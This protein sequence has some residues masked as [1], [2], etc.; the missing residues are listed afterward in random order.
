[1]SFIHLHVYSAYSLLAS[2]ASVEQLVANA[3]A[4]GYSALALTDMNNMYGAIKFYKE[5]SKRSIK[6][7]LGVTVDVAG[8]DESGKSYPIVLLASNN[9]GF[10]NLIKITSAVQTK[11]PEGIPVKWLRHYAS[12]LFALS[13]GHAGE[14]EHW[15]EQGEDDR[16]KEA[17]LFYEGIFGKGRF[18]ISLHDQ[19]LEGQRDVME[20]LAVLAREAGVKTA[21]ANTVHYLQKEDAFAQECLL[22]I[23]NGTK[24]QD[25][26]REKLG[27]S[28]FYLKTSAEMAELFSDYPDALEN[29]LK[30]ADECNVMIDLGSRHLPSFPVRKGETAEEILDRL[31]R[32]GLTE[33]YGHP[34][35]EHKERLEYELSVIKKMNFSD[36]FLIVWDFMKFA[37]DNGIL[38]GPGRGS[39][40]GSIVAYSLY[41]TDVDPIRHKLLFERFLNPERITMPDIDIDFPD[42]RRD[43]VIDYV[44]GRYGR[45]HVAQI[46]TFGTLAAK[47]AAR[48]VGR[49]FGLNSNEL[50][51]LSRQIPSKP[52]ITLKSAYKES[53]GLRTFVK[54]SETNQKLFETALKI[55]G[56]PRHTSTHA[57]GVV[58]SEKPLPDVIPIQKGHGDVLLTQYSMEDVEEAGLLKMDF[59]GLRNLSLIETILSSIARKTGRKIDIRTIPLKDEETYKLLSRGETT[60]IFQLESDGMRKVLTRLLPS[61]FEDIVAV[62]AL[63]RPGPMENIPLFIDRKHGRKPIEYPHAD[64]KDILE[65]TYGVIVYQEQIMQIASR[66]AG[67]SLG[68]ADL[69]RRAVSKKKKDV[70]DRERAHFLRGAAGKG[71]DAKVAGTVYDYIVRFANYGF[72][73]SHAVAY[74]FISYQLAYL[75]THY[76]VH[77]MAALMSSSAGNEARVSQYARELK[78]MGYSLL[79]PSINKSGYSFLQEER[80]IRYSLAAIK[81]V[82]GASLKEIFRVRKQKPFTD[83][84]DFCIRVPQKAIN[85]KTMEALVNSGAFDEFGHDRAVLLA[86]LDV[87]AEHAQLVAPEGDEQADLFNG[88][89]FKIV[90]KYVQVDPLRV[91]DR[92]ALEKE[93]LGIYLSTHPV[94]MFEKELAAAGAVPASGGSAGRKA[95]VGAYMIGL[96]KIRTKKGES[97]A[98]LT[99]SDAGGET[100]A[101]VFPDVYRR[102]S[103]L[104]IQGQVVL[105]EGKFEERGGNSQFIIQSVLDIE[106]EASQAASKEHKL[107]LKVEKELSSPE[108]LNNLKLILKKYKGCI[109]V[110]LHYASIDKTV[111]LSEEYQVD[112]S[113]GCLE[114]LGSYLGSKHVVLKK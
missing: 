22:A 114:E 83:L 46:A 25:D 74:S 85:R 87:A 77:F 24:L 27:S 107:Y 32:A 5:C 72:N 102:F 30:I 51:R 19:G 1:M 99:L 44:A 64:L 15:A 89:E 43:E 95:R 11:S 70:L 16:A 34:E 4:K 69:L 54:E 106:K 57:A 81:G 42:H 35:E 63:Y 103:Q 58:I 78:N 28:E 55:E 17:A 3:G 52:G 48:D 97:M 111:L 31:C 14:I 71:Y 110:I 109:P 68:E 76:P 105:L 94:S 90:P 38:T 39:A 101:V 50:D 73:R 113:A 100:E 33:R 2:T 41:I 49:V 93:A 21:A 13:P 6:P 7:I 91:E 96:K 10:G 104:L 88:N 80:G 26:D 36:Y 37:R 56:L 67:F 29:T 79:P 60:G 62:N 45:M 84:F 65:D 23:K 82:S 98:F 75:K 86:T 112:G 61:A 20:R 8:R 40:A 108:K 18:F 9:T 47:A 59:L 12:G 66:M 92:L 53:E